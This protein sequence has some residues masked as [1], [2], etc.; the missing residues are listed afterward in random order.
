MPGKYEGYESRLNSFN[1]R[2]KVNFSFESYDSQS[3]KEKNLATPLKGVKGISR[4]NLKYR[5][6]FLNIYKECVQNMVDK[7]LN[8][9]RPEELVQEF[10]KL[11]GDY[12][13]YCNDNGETAPDAN[14]GWRGTEHMDAMRTTVN[15][16][17]SPRVARES[18][19]YLSGE[20][21]VRDVRAYVRS[22]AEN[23]GSM[24]N[25]GPEELANVMVYREAIKNAV[26]SRPFWWKIIHPFKNNAEQKAVGVLN[27][28]VS[29]N[30]QNVEAAQYL[31]DGE[32]IDNAKNALESASNHLEEELADRTRR[33]ERLNL[34]FL[35]E[36]AN[37]REVSGR[38]NEH[39][40]PQR[41]NNR[42]V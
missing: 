27:D 34:D 35:S 2:Y 28:L 20:L 4:E 31:V 17:R 6:A 26:E 25:L 33:G 18:E 7:K 29:I 24:S 3:L 8:T 16:I 38:V 12:R 39:Q 9:F 41:T 42:Q 13:R 30:M 32:A 22:L 37:A 5:N 1:N 10:E 19:R 36:N 40:A 23:N 11:M 21:R 15:S 14:G